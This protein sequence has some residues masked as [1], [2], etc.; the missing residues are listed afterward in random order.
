MEVKKIKQAYD[1]LKK[2]DYLAKKDDFIT[3]TE[4]SNGEGYANSWT[5]RCNQLFN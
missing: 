1:N 4:W 3:V 2:Y 5:V